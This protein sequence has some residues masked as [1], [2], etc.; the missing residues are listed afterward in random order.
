MT[1]LVRAAAS[2]AISTCCTTGVHA[3]PCAS[4][5]YE[6]DAAEAQATAE[7]IAIL[8]AG[9]TTG[10]VA[11]LDPEVRISSI[12]AGFAIGALTRSVSG[13][14]RMMGPEIEISVSD[15]EVCDRLVS[16]LA[17]ALIE[18]SMLSDKHR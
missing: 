8:S 17:A 6:H 3:V 12:G 11:A 2:A 18:I 14:G 4:G 7:A 9:H 15:A 5:A 10:A 16:Q 1:F 13:A